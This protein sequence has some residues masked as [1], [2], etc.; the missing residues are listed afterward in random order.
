MVNIISSLG[1]I[2]GTAGE[3]SE[4]RIEVYRNGTWGTVCD[5]IF[6]RSD[7]DTA[8]RQWGA[9][10]PAVSWRTRAGYG[11]G[12]GPILLDNAN[13]ANSAMLE[14]LFYC[15]IETTHNC[16]HSEDVGVRCPNVRKFHVGYLV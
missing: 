1:L 11:P 3:S 14:S 7:A 13:C 9:R 2:N 4:G 10:T 6:G 8:C 5:D 15:S 12:T 16:A